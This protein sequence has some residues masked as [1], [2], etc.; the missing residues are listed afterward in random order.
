[1]RQLKS[2]LS[3]IDFISDRVGKLASYLIIFMTLILVYE[4]VMR[5]VFGRLTTW[6]HE[7][8]EFVF[9]S[10]FLLAGAYCVL[11]RSHINVDII[12]AR[13]SVRVKAITDVTVTA[14]AFF[15][16]FGILLWNGII[17]ARDSIMILEV[18]STFWA[19]P[20][21]P[22]KTMVPIAALLLVLQG[23]AKFIRDLITAVTGRELI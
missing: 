21:Y 23:L 22:I 15:L 6:A 1:M 17:M 2:I 13:F 16:L 18:S 19:P 5:Y 3:V 7:L 10:H 14:I 9:G 20:I 8:T 4:V 12:Y 11:H